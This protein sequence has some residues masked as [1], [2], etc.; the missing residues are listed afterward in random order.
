MRIAKSLSSD[1]IYKYLNTGKHVQQICD[2]A[3]L[4]KGAFYR[5]LKEYSLPYRNSMMKKSIKIS[6]ECLSY[7]FQQYSNTDMS[8][9]SICDEVGLHESELYKLI[10]EYNIPKRTE[11]IR[12]KEKFGGGVNLKLANNFKSKH[13]PKPE[14]VDEDQFFSLSD[15]KAILGR[16]ETLYK[17][18]ESLVAEN[19]DLSERVKKIQELLK[20]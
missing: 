1:V 20:I 12:W 14:S 11:S 18:K 4:S 7:V 13:S 6:K 19:K 10:K 17:E 9:K 5:L 3:G 16:L 15:L 2:E 8:V